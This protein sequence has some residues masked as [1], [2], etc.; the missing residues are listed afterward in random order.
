MTDVFHLVGRV[1]LALPLE[2]HFIR[3][4]EQ[5]FDDDIEVI[6]GQFALLSISQ[7]HEQG[8]KTMPVSVDLVFE[9]VERR[10]GIPGDALQGVKIRQSLPQAII[11]LF[12]QLQ[13]YLGTIL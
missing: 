6:C 1:S 4:V 7:K 8:A 12:E 3:E 2:P 5:T 11:E 13:S 10:N 9:T